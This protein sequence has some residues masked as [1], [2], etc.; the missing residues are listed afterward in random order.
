MILILF[1]L[2]PRLI[3]TLLGEVHAPS[4]S[5]LDWSLVVPKKTVDMGIY[6]NGRT[7]YFNKKYRDLTKRIGETEIRQTEIW[8]DSLSQIKMS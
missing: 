3:Y 5:L 7:I 6:V 4:H 8:K 2:H 1:E